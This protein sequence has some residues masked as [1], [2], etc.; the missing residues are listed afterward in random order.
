MSDKPSEI[1]L[2]RVVNFT[3]FYSNAAVVSLLATQLLLDF[4]FHDISVKSS[5]GHTLIRLLI[6]YL[7]LQVI[8][9]SGFIISTYTKCNI[10]SLLTLRGPIIGALI[11]VIFSISMQTW[12]RNISFLK[13]NGWFIFGFL[14]MAYIGFYTVYPILKKDPVL[15]W[16]NIIPPSLS[17]LLYA[18]YGFTLEPMILNSSLAIFL[19]D[20]LGF[21]SRI[22]YVT[23]VG[24]LIYVLYFPYVFGSSFIENEEKICLSDKS[25]SSSST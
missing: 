14:T 5:R 9:Q 8:T 1:N 23:F 3:A 16:W 7:V 6:L 12:A 13:N 19:S 20:K 15:S 11:I 24:G 2:G 21:L 25:L 18:I 17:V 10:P 4:S 22:L